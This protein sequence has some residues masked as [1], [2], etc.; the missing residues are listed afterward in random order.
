MTSRFVLPL[1]ALA[2]L[3]CGGAN[4]IEA[5]LTVAGEP[6]R[7]DD[8]ALCL[9]V[10]GRLS[11]GPVGQGYGVSVHLELEGTEA[12]TTLPNRLS[13]RAS[14]WVVHTSGSRS[15]SSSTSSGTV[16]LDELALPRAH[17]TFD[18]MSGDLDDDEGMPQITVANGR[19]ACEETL[20]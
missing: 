11:V 20:R 9:E 2:A 5:D 7:V 1:V 14:V 3:H 12:P 16:V 10:L 19:F 13:S 15:L 18:G 8:E 6:V 4:R 17:G